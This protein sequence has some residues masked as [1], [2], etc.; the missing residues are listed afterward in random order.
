MKTNKIISAE[1]RKI[2]SRPGVYIVSILLAA[3]MVFC[4]FTFSPTVRSVSYSDIQKDTV[5]EIYSLFTN[6]DLYKPYCDSLV[7]STN[8]YIDATTSGSSIKTSVDRAYNNYVDALKDYKERVNSSATLDQKNLNR[9]LLYDKLKQLQTQIFDQGVE[10]TISGEYK[11]LMS[12]DNYNAVKQRFSELDLYLRQQASTAEQ[13]TAN[14][15]KAESFQSFISATLDKFIYPTISNENLDSIAEIRAECEKRLVS[16]TNDMNSLIASLDS[17]DSQ[18]SIANRKKMNSYIEG[19]YKTSMLYS[20]L[21]TDTVKEDTLGSYTNSEI[22]K[23]KFFEDYDKYVAQENFTRNNYLW[24]SKTFDTTYALPIAFNSAS[25]LNGANAY[26]FMFYALEI[27]S[28]IILV[29]VIYLACNSIAGERSDGTL[30]LIAIKPINRSKI[31][32]GKLL[33]CTYISLILL[34]FSSVVAFIVGLFLY[35]ATSSSILV[36][37]NAMSAFT[38]HPVLYML[39]YL[40][41][42]FIKLFVF[43]NIGM[44]ISSLINNGTVASMIGLLLYFVDLVAGMLIQNANILRFMPLSNLDLIPFFGNMTLGNQTNLLAKL[45]ATTTPMPAIIWVPACTIIGLIL[46][47]NILGKLTFKRKDLA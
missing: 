22:N 24:Q 19:Y 1:F 32:R 31:Y 15:K 38:I 34:I 14:L 25:N 35:G 20:N 29:Y 30:K 40:I 3:V 45:F 33:F 46:L 47:S 18:K 11:L 12:V 4:A 26:D 17:E 27:F 44:L 7:A 8:D 9:S 39:F 43:I 36:V 41:S 23:L 5:S 13:H 6:D 37:F 28:F 10:L 16:Y 21:I 2:L 42:L